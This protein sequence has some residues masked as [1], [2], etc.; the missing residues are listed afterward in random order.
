L[1][2]T[3]QNSYIDLN[4]I[5][6]LPVIAQRLGSVI[7][8]QVLPHIKPEIDTLLSHSVTGALAQ[9]PAYQG[10][11]ILPGF[12]QLSQQLSLQ[13]SAEVSKNLYLTLQKILSDPS[14]GAL[15]GKVISSFV[16]HFR[17]EIQKDNTLKEIQTLTTELIEELKINYVE[18]IATEDTDKLKAD[19]YKLY[20]TTQKMR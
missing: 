7:V 3:N 14:S 18:R 1:E 13:I 10:L 19:M 16:H 2:V 12:D 11:R 4:G 15:T 5:D 8:N 9:A 17:E 6:E 20:A